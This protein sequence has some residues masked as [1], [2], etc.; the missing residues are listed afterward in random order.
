MCF[1]F[2][3]RIGSLF[4]LNLFLK[5]CFAVVKITGYFNSDCIVVCKG[6]RTEVFSV[7]LISLTN[8]LHSLKHCIWL[9][10]VYA[11]PIPFHGLWKSTNWW[12]KVFVL[13]VGRRVCES[14]KKEVGSYYSIESLLLAATSQAITYKL[15]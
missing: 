5:I 9:L 13:R 2:S 7:S 11:K 10:H 4:L 3:N 8:F 15:W 12:Q 1:F 14:K 6:L